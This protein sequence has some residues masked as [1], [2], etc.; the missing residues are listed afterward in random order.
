[1]D[2]REQLKRLDY[3][4]D[5]KVNIE[6]AAAVLNDRLSGKTP[7][8]TFGLGVAVGAVVMFFLR[9]IL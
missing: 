4:G 1:M 3:T 8:F 7:A 2:V 6:D 5:G 9:P